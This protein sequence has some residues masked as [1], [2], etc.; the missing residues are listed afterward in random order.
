MA[1]IALAALPTSTH[2]GKMVLFTMIAPLAKCR[3]ML[4]WVFRPTVTT[5][6]FVPGLRSV[7]GIL[8]LFGTSL[9]F[10]VLVVLLV[11]GFNT[12]S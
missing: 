4:R 8:S 5:T 6:L 2:I 7:F 10:P 9:E 11:D 1:I 12:F 3:A